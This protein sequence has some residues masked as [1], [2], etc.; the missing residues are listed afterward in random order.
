MTQQFRCHPVARDQSPIRPPQQHPVPDVPEHNIHLG[1]PAG[2]F[3]LRLRQRR[4]VRNHTDMTTIGHG[5]SAYV[6][7]GSVGTAS[8][9]HLRSRDVKRH[10]L[11]K[12]LVRVAW[13]ILAGDGPPLDHLL[14]VVA[15][16]Q[17]C[18]GHDFDIGAIE[19]S[20]PTVRPVQA[21]PLRNASQQRFQHARAAA[22]LVLGR[23]QR[24]DIDRRHCPSTVRGGIRRDFH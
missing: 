4:D 11:G 5:R 15:H 6:D 8:P 9:A 7:Y 23:S 19:H 14:Q 10:L 22:R 20:H 17:R 1:G 24:T 12:H 21:N 3:L 13:P 2:E 18:T 16:R